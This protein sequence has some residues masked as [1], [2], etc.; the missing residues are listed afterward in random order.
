MYSA[1]DCCLF[2]HPISFSRSKE[3][4]SYD[5]ADFDQAAIFLYLDGHDPQSIQEQRRRLLKKKIPSMFHPVIS[6]PLLHTKWAWP[7]FP[8]ICICMPYINMLN[9]PVLCLILSW[10][11]VFS[12]WCCL[13][14]WDL[15]GN[16]PRVKSVTCNSPSLPFARA[17]SKRSYKYSFFQFLSHSFPPAPSRAL[18]WIVAPYKHA[19][20]PPSVAIQVYCTC[21]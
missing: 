15:F 21:S 3:S 14:S 9:R 19:S 16:S 10:F 7:S 1:T 5:M 6:Y 18:C 12:S 4:T 20:R 13:P 2:H 11:R 8:C 17:W